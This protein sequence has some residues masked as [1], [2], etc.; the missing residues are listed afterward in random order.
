MYNKLS[1]TQQ[2]LG[3]LKTSD[4]HDVLDFLKR[5]GAESSRSRKRSTSKF[6]VKKLK[7][8]HS[9]AAEAHGL[10][11]PPM[12]FVDRHA[13]VDVWK[14]SKQ[15][16]ASLMSASIDSYGTRRKERSSSKGK[17]KSFAYVSIMSSGRAAGKS[18]SRSRSHSKPASKRRSPSVASTKSQSKKQKK[19]KPLRNRM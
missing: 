14:G 15:P 2:K 4:R 7:N 10:R 17:K 18:T 6:R 16:N 11:Q 19:L 5:D 12:Q 9:I 8:V 13:T 1:N 3:V